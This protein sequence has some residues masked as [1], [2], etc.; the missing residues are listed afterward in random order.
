MSDQQPESGTGDNINVG[1]IENSNVVAV[2]A[3]A[4]AVYNAGL[5]A[6]AVAALVVELKRVDQPEVWDGR[7]PYLGLTAFQ[8]SDAQFFFGREGLNEATSVAWHPDGDRLASA[9]GSVVWRSKDS[10]V[11]IW[12]VASGTE[13]ARLEGHESEA[14]WYYFMEIRIVERASGVNS[15]AWHPDGNR[16]ASASDDNTIHIRN[17]S[18]GCDRISSN[19][20]VQEWQEYVSPWIP[21]QATCPDLPSPPLT[22]ETVINT[23][24]ADVAII[25][26]VIG[27]AILV[28]VTVVWLIYRLVRFFL[29]RIR[30]RKVSML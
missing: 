25:I 16:L 28:L 27:V 21:Y 18:V 14:F 17:A 4:T 8:E 3:G 5:S 30:N 12:D 10:I 1:N 20:T 13:L 9:S 7:F 23:R 19:L 26:I 29:K 2:G 15:I 22:L 6:E 11:R 24:N